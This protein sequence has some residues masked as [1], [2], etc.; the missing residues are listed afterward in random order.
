MLYKT[1]K[2]PKTPDFRNLDFAKY[3]AG[4]APPLDN[5][6]VLDSIALR[7]GTPVD[8]P[9]CFPMDGNDTYG[10]CVAAAAAHAVTVYSGL[11]G[12]R[13]IPAGADVV[14]QYMALTGGQDS[15]LSELDTMKTWKN[16]GLFGEKILGFAELL[17]PTDHTLVKQALSFFG[18]LFTGIQC[19]DGIV[20]QFKSGTW[21][22]G[23]P[24]NDGHGIYAYAFGPEGVYFFTWGGNVL[25]PWDVF[26]KFVDELYAIAPQEAADP[27]Y[28]PGFDTAA[29][30]AD[31]ALVGVTNP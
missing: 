20:D 28:A 24:D 30:L 6:N 25:M 14:S 8:I 2:L 31:L 10:D 5:W 13:V 23:N 16:S 4:L 9:A 21:T 15:G 7:I 27:T 17:D 3:A 26:D 29:F 11:D 18:G 1:G 22:G 19:W 12:K